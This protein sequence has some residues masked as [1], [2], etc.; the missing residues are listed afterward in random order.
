METLEEFYRFMQELSTLRQTIVGHFIQR[1]ESPHHIESLRKALSVIDELPGDGL[2]K[3]LLAG[4]GEVTVTLDYERAE[5]EKDIRFLDQRERGSDRFLDEYNPHFEEN[6]R[7]VTDFLAGRTYRAFVTDRDGT[8]NNYCGRY[9]SSHQAVYNAVLLSR[10]VEGPV[11]HPVILTSAPL[12]DHGLLSLSA[13]PDNVVHYA[14]SKGREYLSKTGSSGRMP[15]QEEQERVLKQLN[16]RLSKLLEEEE[17]RQFGLIGS[18]V[19]FK[20]GQTTVSRQD[21][22]GSVDE[23]KSRRFLDEV[24]SM[25]RELDPEETTLKIEDTGLDIEVMLTVEGSKDF[26]KGNGIQFLDRELGLELESGPTL[27]CGDTSSDVPMVEA[28][29]SACRD[30]YAVFVTDD[31]ELKERLAQVAPNVRYVASPD[32]LVAALARIAAE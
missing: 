14:G 22:H 9:R 8:I 18:A 30:T 25:V 4:A 5:L 28:A 17:Y 24:T 7:A 19:Q 31:E 12:E 23:A 29:L 10:F 20:F 2:D 26:D 1:T 11:A 27:I 13:M 6:V 21:I 16:N 3:R 15:I 32:V